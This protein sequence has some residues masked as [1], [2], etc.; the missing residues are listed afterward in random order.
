MS[1]SPAIRGNC[2]AAG[3]RWAVAGGEY[4]VAVGASSGAANISGAAGM[5]QVDQFGVLSP[6]AERRFE[7]R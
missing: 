1:R 6:I 3:K 5:A 2:D 7:C 4:R